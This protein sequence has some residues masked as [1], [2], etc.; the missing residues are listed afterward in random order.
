MAGQIAEAYV[1]I[2]PTTQGIASGISESLGGE[3]EKGGKSFGSRFLGA[4]GKL[5]AAA[6][7]GKLF[8]SAIEA[9]GEIQQSFGGLDTIYGEA[10][11]GAKQFAR[12]AAS[13]GI[14]MNSYAEQAVSFG[15]A[16]KQAYGGDTQAAMNAAN[17]AIL[18]MADNSAKMGTDMSAIQS[19]YQGFAKQ[20]YTML[21]NLKLGYGG[22]K[23]EMERLLADAQAI[24]GV[25]YNIDNLGDVYDA[26][27][28][29]QTELGLTGVA[30]QEA[31]TTLS[32]SFNAMK[33]SAKNFLAD[34]ALGNDISASLS[35]LT[36]SVITFAG[37][38]L[39]MIQNIVA[40]APQALVQLLTGLGPMLLSTGIE[41]IMNLGQGIAAALP[42]LIS[43]LSAM[44]PQIVSGFA[45]VI[46]QLLSVGAQI[47]QALAQGVLQAL[48]GLIA[49]LPG[50]IT[51]IAN[52]LT[53]S[54]GVIVSAGIELFNGLVQ[55]LPT[56]VAALVAAAPEIVNALISALL[57]L[58]G[59]LQSSATQLW[60]SLV[61]G[62]QTIA[63]PL[64]SAAKTAISNAVNAVKSAAG[65]A[66]AAA[67]E[68]A[69]KI[70]EG[71]RS[72]VSQAASA[73]R[74]IGSNILSAISAFAG[75]LVSAGKNLIIG[76]A[77]G[78]KASVGAAIAAA[79][80][81]VGAVVS[82]AKSALGIASPS[83]VFADIGE[84]ITLG[85][86]EGIV[87]DTKPVTDAID[88]VAAMTTDGMDNALAVNAA[89]GVATDTE[90][91]GDL[92][93]LIATV[94]ALSRKIDEIGVYLD[95]DR[96]VGQLV[97]RMDSALGTRSALTGRGQA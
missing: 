79:K 49:A 40:A 73:A 44:I 61:T 43:S 85:L 3:G 88:S 72:G 48:P 54:I 11:A 6:G 32:G 94:N 89:L 62:L 18:D 76:L 31:K 70:I 8:K 83:K 36:D 52:G 42:G 5:I 68:V 58:A 35:A 12:E 96:L 10:S 17:T 87:E 4:A 19:A 34:L 60:T 41:A 29:I 65:N 45:T 63:G 56:V 16:L 30:A 23:T 69:M 74:E 91:T 51:D 14:S 84:N 64:I 26:I 9:G 39:P 59:T 28:V 1:Q 21:D 55:A 82:A 78:I 67:K 86:A 20:N 57:S 81:A 53:S 46:P 7:V 47:I 15:A 75:Q 25:E 77:Q 13:A 22:T 37:N 95:G 2:I 50:M 92:R 71:I 97:N 93:V 24:S 90:A 66:L 27:H 33:A 38:V 80:S